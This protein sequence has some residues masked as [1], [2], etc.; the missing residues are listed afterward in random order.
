M[1]KNNNNKNKQDNSDQKNWYKKVTIEKSSRI[2][3]VF[4]RGQ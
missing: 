3:K 4:L 1:D 2:L